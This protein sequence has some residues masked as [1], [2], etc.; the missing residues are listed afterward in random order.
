[1]TAILSNCYV[2]TLHEI[3]TTIGKKKTLTSVVF[4]KGDYGNK[5]YGKTGNVGKVKL[6]YRHDT[7]YQI[8]GENVIV[9]NTM[10]S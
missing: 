4:H 6:A 2:Y 7:S 8:A 3:T 9:N 5:T 1:M 10:L